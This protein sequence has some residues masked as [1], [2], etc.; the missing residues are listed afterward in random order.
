MER[1][2]A[3]TPAEAHA[4]HR[5]LK[6]LLIFIGKVIAVRVAVGKQD[7][8]NTAARGRLEEEETAARLKSGGPSSFDIHRPTWATRAETEGNGSARCGASEERVAE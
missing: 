8:T 4:L 5:H 6:S 1:A 2:H 7:Q 3:H